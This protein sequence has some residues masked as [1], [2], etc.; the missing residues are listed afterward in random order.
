MV[1]SESFW[2]RITVFGSLPTASGS[3]SVG[4]GSVMSDFSGHNVKAGMYIT[5]RGNKAKV[6]QGVCQQ[7]QGRAIITR[8]QCISCLV[9]ILYDQTNLE[10]NLLSDSWMSSYYCVGF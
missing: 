8:L 5:E 6:D 3:F 4:S 9:G 2:F 10:N 1:R 7:R